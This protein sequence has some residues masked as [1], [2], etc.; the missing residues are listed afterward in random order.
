MLARVLTVEAPVVLVDEP[1]AS[2]DPR[3]QLTVMQDLKA[4]SRRGTL[5]VAVTHDIGLAYRLADDVVLMDKGRIVAFGSPADVL[6]DARLASVYG[7]KVARQ[8]AG[9]ATLLTPLEPC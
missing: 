5:V 3:H 1:T 8:N 6:T 2:L 9:D 7:I 4:E